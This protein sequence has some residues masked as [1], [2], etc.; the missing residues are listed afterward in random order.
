MNLMKYISTRGGD[1]LLSFE[2]VCFSV[3]SLSDRALT[4][5]ALFPRPYSLASLQTVVSTSRSTSHPSPQTGT[6]NGPTT[7][8]PTS[9]SQCS[10]STFPQTKYLVTNCVSSLT[11]HTSRSDTRTSPL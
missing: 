1:E 3:R 10:R 2:D 6:L 11:S 5:I 4:I 7:L 8:S 9:P